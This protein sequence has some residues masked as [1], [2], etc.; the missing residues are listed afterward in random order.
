MLWVLRKI[1]YS[2]HYDL[3]SDT[4]ICFLRILHE[5]LF[6]LYLLS[7]ISISFVWNIN[8]FWAKDLYL[9]EMCFYQIEFFDLKKKGLSTNSPFCKVW[10]RKESILFEIVGLYEVT[11]AIELLVHHHI[12][13]NARIALAECRQETLYRS[14]RL[15]R[16]TEFESLCSI[17][18]LNSE[19]SF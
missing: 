18:E 1:P 6:Y 2:W 5:D 10:S 19:D 14:G 15:E 13:F 3:G 17:N 9:L 12:L 11:S 8:I 4:L 7:K 16:T